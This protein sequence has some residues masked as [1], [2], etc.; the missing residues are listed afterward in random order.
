M[1]RYR[2]A[3]VQYRMYRHGTI[4]NPEV[5]GRDEL[6]DYMNNGI[7]WINFRG[8]G[9]GGIWA[10]GNPSV[11]SLDD[12][13]SLENKGQ[14]PVVTSLTCFTGDFASSRDC[15]GEAIIRKPDAGAVAFFGTTSVGWTNADFVLMQ[16]MLTAF[17]SQPGL[18]IGE[19]IQ[20]GKT[21]YR[22]Q[23]RTDLAESEVHQYNLIG[24]PC[25]RFAFPPDS[26]DFTLTER[27][28]GRGDSVRFIWER[29]NGTAAGA[30]RGNRFHDPNPLRCRDR[31]FRRAGTRFSPAS[32]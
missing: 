17:R 11:M 8:H 16:N 6:L 31:L 30:H 13:D 19:I 26:N 7:A 23:N 18:T 10:D 27:S 1:N 2:E 5:G 21:L 15:L 12:V 32:G 24:D 20:K 29:T 25:V 4:S 14:Y 28:I 22:M 3:S 9:G